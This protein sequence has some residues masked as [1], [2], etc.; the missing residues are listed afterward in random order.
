MAG[1]LRARR[2]DRAIVAGTAAAGS[3]K[4]TSPIDPAC[5]Y[6]RQLPTLLRGVLSADD[7][8]QRHEHGPDTT[9]WLLAWLL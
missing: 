8:W 1:A 3:E 5:T 7:R 6:P 9:V 2:Q 4:P